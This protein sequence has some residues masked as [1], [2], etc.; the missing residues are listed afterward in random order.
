MTR[1]PWKSTVFTLFPDIFP[2]PLG[3]SII[4]KALDEKSWE[5]NV[6]NLRNYGVDKRN[7]V[8]NAAFGGGPGM[9]LRPDV[10]DAGFREAFQESQPNALIYLSPRGK[11]LTQELI[12]SLTTVSH[13]G[14]LCGRF[15]GVDQRVLDAWN[16]E[17]VS[18]GDF[19]LTGGEIAAMALIES[20]VRLLPGV[21]LN[22][23]SLKEE[24]FSRG[25]LEYPHYTRPRDWRGRNVPE[26]LLTGHHEKIRAWRLAQAEK[27][28]HE[29]RPDLW[30]RYRGMINELEG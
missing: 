1:A 28:T 8:D 9:V 21:L 10:I 22:P 13:V 15:E 23:E 18:L 20:C 2:G 19:V 25:L 16:V 11:P 3:A 30:I 26:V 29:R 5:L 7:T 14:L 17:E 6:V 4:G 27:M 12:Q 24:S